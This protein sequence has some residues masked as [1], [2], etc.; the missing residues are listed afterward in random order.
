M[1][2]IY[3]KFRK[4]Y[5]TGIF[6]QMCCGSTRNGNTW[7]MEAHFNLHLNLEMYLVTFYMLKKTKNIADI[8]T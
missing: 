5:S 8:V 6:L 7:R 4:I 3:C 2:K 1:V